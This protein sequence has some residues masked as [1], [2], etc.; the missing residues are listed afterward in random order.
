MGEGMSSSQSATQLYSPGVRLPLLTR[1]IHIGP[2]PMSD[3]AHCCCQQVG[4]L[5]LYEEGGAG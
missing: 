4:R 2:R 3:G 1:W 5:A